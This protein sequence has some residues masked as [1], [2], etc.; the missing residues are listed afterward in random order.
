MKRSE[1]YYEWNIVFTSPGI[2]KKSFVQNVPGR[3]I[4]RENKRRENTL[5]CVFCLILCLF[6]TNAM[7]KYRTMVLMAE[8]VLKC[9]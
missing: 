3:E 1:K 4:V 8:R 9:E 7:L 2:I 6:V 5:F